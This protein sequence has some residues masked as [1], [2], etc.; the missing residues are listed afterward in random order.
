[1]KQ[2]MMKLIQLRLEKKSLDEE[3]NKLQDTILEFDFD[4]VEIEWITVSKGSK[5]TVSLNKD[6]DI[7]K[8]QEFYPDLCSVKV[9]VSTLHKTT[10][11][12][13]SQKVSEFIK[14]DGLPK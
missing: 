7:K 8:I 12:F 14:V 10:K 4:K 5:T 1:M 9:D 6:A 13:T 11:E 2:E 3:I